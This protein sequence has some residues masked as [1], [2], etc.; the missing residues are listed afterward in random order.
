MDELLITILNFS[1]M[2][3]NTIDLKDLEVEI[4]PEDQQLE[5]KG[6]IV[7]DDIAGF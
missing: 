2:K 3:N 5:V 1:I 4:L 6:G 7:H